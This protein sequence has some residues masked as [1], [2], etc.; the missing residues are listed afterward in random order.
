VNTS[1]FISAFSGSARV[2]ATAALGI[3]LRVA[4]TGEHAWTCANQERLRD[5]PTSTHS[6][7]CTR[8]AR[9]LKRA[10]ISR[11]GRPVFV[12]NFDLLGGM[13]LN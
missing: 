8:E 2:H 12:S 1:R 9:G 5:N 13:R 3:A 7:K 6:E 4:A 10:P 11:D